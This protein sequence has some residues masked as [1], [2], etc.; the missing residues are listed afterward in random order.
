MA[1]SSNNAQSILKSYLADDAKVT[2]KFTFN[3]KTVN[4]LREFMKA[5]N[6]YSEQ[7]AVRFIV[8]AI[9]IKEGYIK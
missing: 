5:R 2:F 6:I 9:L 1:L 7:D 4:G 3:G 8:N